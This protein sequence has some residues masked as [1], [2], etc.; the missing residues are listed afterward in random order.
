MKFEGGYVMMGIPKTPTPAYQKVFFYVDGQTYQVRRVLLLDAQ[1][2]RNRFD[3]V[4]PIV[5]KAVTKDEFEF[6]PPKGTRIIKP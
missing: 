5:N 3:F 1:R 6:T 4:S 2:N